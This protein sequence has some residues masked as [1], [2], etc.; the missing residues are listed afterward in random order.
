[1]KFIVLVL[2][3]VSSLANAAEWTALGEN[4]FGAFYVDKATIVQAQG[5][6]KV[7]TLLNWVEPHL[8]TGTEKKYYHSEIAQ[9][10][11]DCKNRQLAF[12]SRTMY[13]DT[14][15]MGNVVFSIALALNDIRLRAFAADSTGEYLVKFVC[16]II[17][18]TPSAGR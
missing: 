11:L 1:M 13:A 4:D 12:G 14:D 3:M 15:G 8:V 2:L 6:T 17:Q 10:Y 5:L 16:P 7:D 9:T 18:K